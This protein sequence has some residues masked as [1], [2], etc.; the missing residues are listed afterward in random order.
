[1]IV[2]TAI[3]YTDPTETQVTPNSQSTQSI[4]S[5]STITPEPLNQTLTT[6]IQR[7]L[8]PQNNNSSFG[9]QI[10]SPKHPNSIRIA[11]QN[12]NGIQKAK[13]W[14]ELK[15]LS[16]KLT[17]LNIDIFGAAETNLK[18]TF[19]RN[20]QVK[21]ILQKSQKTCSISTSSN[22]EESFSAYQPRGTLTAIF[23]KY[24]GRISTIIHDPTPLGRWSGF[25][26]HTNFGHKLNILTVYQSTKSDG[27]HTTYQQQS[28]YFRTQG[29]QHP[30][31]RKLL[32]Q[33]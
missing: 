16:N 1:M 12:V 9:D 15:S 27:I 33:D 8:T 7:T 29:N 19:A 13:S 20:Q 21:T 14:N 10:T 28:H 32:I 25:K 17:K 26:L 11:F 6:G 22:K 3:T 4:P 31:P 18:W 24:V 23:H 30:D 5:Q 2:S